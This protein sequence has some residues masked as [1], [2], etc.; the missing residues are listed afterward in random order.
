LRD[1]LGLYQ[2]ST[3]E[4]KYKK[5]LK[6]IGDVVKANRQLK[7]ELDKL[8]EYRNAGQDNFNRINQ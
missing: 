2:N 3:I 4:A 8:N 1:E 7:L 5:A 6:E